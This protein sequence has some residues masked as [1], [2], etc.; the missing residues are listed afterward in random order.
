[1][2]KLMNNT[3]LAKS[4]SPD[5]DFKFWIFFPKNVAWNLTSVCDTSKNVNV[6]CLKKKKKNSL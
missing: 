6:S 3:F 5:E 2:K 4:C 1:M